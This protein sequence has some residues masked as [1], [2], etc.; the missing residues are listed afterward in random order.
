MTSVAICDI[1]PVAIEG[2]R[3]LLES[4]GLRVVA[5]H[6]SLPAAMEAVRE[7]HPS[8]L[9]VEKAFG[10]QAVMD[11]IE[12]LRKSPSAPAI[13]VWSS[14]V[15]EIDAILFFQA[16][17]QGVMRKTAPLSDLLSSIRSVAAGGTW[18]DDDRLSETASPVPAAHSPLTVREMQVMELVQRD[19]KNKEI[20]SLLGIRIGT[21]QVHLKHIFE[22][23]GVRSRH[24]L[25]FAGV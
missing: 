23:T 25:G 2:L 1:E 21:V 7:L 3:A 12:A 19:I 5:A 10:I 14:A 6:A 15:S 24:S 8:L 4:A 11:W 13:I 9:I 20:G 16:G 22:K 17:A 18:R